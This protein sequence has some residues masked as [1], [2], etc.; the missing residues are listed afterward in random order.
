MRAEPGPRDDR[1]GLSCAG[2]PDGTGPELSDSVEALV[3]D[4]LSQAPGPVLARIDELLPRLE[5]QG[6]PEPLLLALHGRAVVLARTGATDTDLVAAC[7]RLELA[8]QE[9]RCPVWIAVACATRAR[10]RLDAGRIGAAMGDLGR[11]DLDHLDRLDQDGALS[12]RAG[13][14]L[15]DILATVHSRLRI[16]DRLD[17]VRERLEHAL[18]HG[19]ALERAWHL[20]TWSGEL[21]ARALEPLA[22]GTGEPDTRLLDRAVSI[23][24]RSCG[25]PEDQ[26]PPALRRALNGVGALAAGYGGSPSRALRLLGEDAFTDPADMPRTPRH[27]V[28]LAAMHSHGLLGSL[29]TARGLD[30]VSDPADGRRPVVPF[31]DLVLEICQARERLWLET[32]AGGDTR[33]VLDRLNGLLS[34]LGWQSLNL[35]SDTARQ[36]LEHRDLREESSMDALTGVANRRTLDEE[37]RHML[38]SGRLPV[39]IVLLDIDG[40]QQINDRH[41]SLVGDEVLRRVAALLTQ[42]MRVGDR[43]ARSG[44]DEFVLL[45]PSTGDQEARQVA[46]RMR[47]RIRGNTWSQLAEGLQVNATT[48]CAALWS[49]SGRRPDKDAEYLL[50]RADEALAQVRRDRLSQG[51]DG[52][53][54]A[55]GTLHTRAV[56]VPA[57]AADG[58]IDDPSGPINGHSGPVNGYN[59]ILNGHSGLP[60]DPG[61][62]LDGDSGVLEDYRRLLDGLR[63][64]PD[65]HG[66]PTGARTGELAP[67]SSELLSSEPPSSDP[68]SSGPLSSARSEPARPGRSRR[69]SAA[70][71]RTDPFAAGRSEPP[72]VPPSGP[73]SVWDSARDEGDAR[74]PVQEPPQRPTSRPAGSVPLPEASSPSRRQGRRSASSPLDAPSA[75][76]PGQPDREVPFVEHRRGPS[77]SPAN[78]MIGGFSPSGGEAGRRPRSASLFD[79]APV[80]PRAVDPPPASPPPGP[81]ATAPTIRSVDELGPI[82]PNPSLARRRNI[83]LG[84][85]GRPSAPL[86]PEDLPPEA[87]PGS[88]PVGQIPE[89]DRDGSPSP[90]DRGGPAGQRSASTSPGRRPRTRHRPPPLD[91]LPDGTGRRTPFG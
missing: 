59:G 20:A 56:E 69:R 31:T 72:S 14:R 11:V 73:P 35:V 52:P 66:G 9:R 17:D 84:R 1:I 26:V 67:L 77:L 50:R 91:P 23:A 78:P 10:I 30:R 75:R 57:P 27:L 19:P 32:H 29:G 24:D 81:A 82:T 44:V 36:A 12:H 16:F 33:P 8:A 61:G 79:P 83:R 90:Y 6:D 42:Q 41:T 49:L 55:A 13:R 76:Q 34:R 22:A 46:S 64:L 40:F 89:Y 86:P 74:S 4:G 63:G 88:A 28:R 38:R 21:A 62:L 39:A 68:L 60:D 2:P 48:G 7:E 80:G 53:T 47:A 54:D 18:R 85:E 3:L 65:G 45:L 58:P 25:L 87:L 70:L 43:L 51:E 5:R 71:G 37:L 15:L